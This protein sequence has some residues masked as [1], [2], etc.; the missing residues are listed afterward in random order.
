[1][2]GFIVAFALFVFP[3]I[4]VPWTNA[5]CIAETWSFNSRGQS[6]CLVA[7]YLCASCMAD[8]ICDISALEGTDMYYGLP[9]SLA[10]SCSWQRWSSICTFD[11][12]TTGI[13]PKPIPPD[14][15]I[16]SWAYYDFTHANVF[17]AAVASQ[18]SGPES[19]AISSAT[20]TAVSAPAPTGSAP[21]PN[22]T[23]TEIIGDIPT[24]KPVESQ[25]GPNSN[26]GAIVGGVVGGV[27]GLGL[28]ALLAYVL[29]QKPR[30]DN[31][32]PNIN[33]SGPSSMAGQASPHQFDTR[34]TPV[35][36]Y[37][38]Y[39]PGDPPAFPIGSVMPADGHQVESIPYSYQPRGAPGQ[40]PYP[41]PHQA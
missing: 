35:V 13:Y 11:Q 29:I 33:H 3:V 14:V 7:S 30:S 25:S 4:A 21:S 15:T 32:M 24:A 1:M 39:N 26:T 34:L 9:Q 40:P 5:T 38:A 12:K 18:Q 8:N 6:P 31:L 10:S 41:A 27:L 36:E 2:L 22:S 28:I 17:N 23:H 20:N 37:K 16:P 19:S